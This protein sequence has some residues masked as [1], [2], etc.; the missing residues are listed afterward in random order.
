M[1]YAKKKNVKMVWVLVLHLPAH[2][3]SFTIRALVFIVGL[4]DAF[5]PDPTRWNVVVPD[6]PMDH[7][8]Q[9]FTGTDDN[10]SYGPK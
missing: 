2:L 7:V 10:V 8:R 3:L 1:E 9:V 6:G 4:H 5:L